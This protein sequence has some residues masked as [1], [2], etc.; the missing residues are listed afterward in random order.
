MKYTNLLINL[1][2]VGETKIQITHS[3]ERKGFNWRLKGFGA[4]GSSMHA[5]ATYCALPQSV[6]PD[7]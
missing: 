4:K 6:F 5:P 1:A 7:Y 3:L 2:L